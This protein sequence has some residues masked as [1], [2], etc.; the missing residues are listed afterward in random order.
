MPW[1]DYILKAEHKAKKFSRC[2]QRRDPRPAQMEAMHGFNIC[3]KDPLEYAE[4]FHALQ[5]NAVFAMLFVHFLP[6]LPENWSY[7]EK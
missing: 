4:V 6:S 2:S 7:Q 5:L 1:L 3:G